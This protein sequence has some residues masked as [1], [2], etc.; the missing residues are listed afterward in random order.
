MIARTRGTGGR[1]ALAREVLRRATFG[2]LRL[3]E[4]LQLLLERGETLVGAELAHRADQLL[5]VIVVRDELDAQVEAG[6]SDEAFE[7]RERRIPPASL[8]LRDL[9]LRLV[10]PLGEL[11]LRQFRAL[12][13]LTNDRPRGHSAY[14]SSYLIRRSLSTRRQH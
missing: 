8:N 9:G 5:A 2:D 13:R 1:A 11:A 7:R 14:D 6:G 3:G 10:S 12:S 4:E